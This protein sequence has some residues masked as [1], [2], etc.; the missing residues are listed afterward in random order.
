MSGA[1]IPGPQGPAGQQG[2]RGVQGGIGAQGPT[3]PCGPTGAR[4]AQGAQ[5]DIGGRGDTGL[6]GIRG[7]T[8]PIGATGGTGP[9]GPGGTGPTGERGITGAT[10]PTGPTGPSGTGPT[11]P[12]VTGPTGP[13]G[14]TGTTGNT[15]PTGPTGSVDTS[16]QNTFSA[17][18]IFSNMIRVGSSEIIFQDATPATRNNG[19]ALV[20]DDLWFETAT[21]LL[22]FWDG[23]RWLSNQLFSHEI[24]NPISAFGYY[25]F[26]FSPTT[27]DSTV[28]DIFVKDLQLCIKQTSFTP[29]ADYFT[30]KVRRYDASGNS[31]AV[32]SGLSN[33]IPS[34]ANNKR[35]VTSNVATMTTYVAH[36]LNVGQVVTIANCEDAT[37][38]GDYVITAIPSPTT[39]SFALTHANVGLT[40]DSSVTYSMGGYYTKMQIALD[41]FQSMTAIQGS[42]FDT[43]AVRVQALALRLEVNG[44]ANEWVGTIKVSY[45]LVHP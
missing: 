24:T 25:E 27:I 28:F 10:G 20:A 14:E 44:G 45:R 33:A 2:P 22:W 13:I 12:S 39:F 40:S 23:T 32:G 1:S 4:G 15:G 34:N 31:A 29:G 19:N 11:G 37:F 16:I 35:Q 42:I 30:A 17:T 5:G 21:N 8:G 9:T 18:Q 43:P 7:M 6:T 41:T 26:V 3:G 38:D 36:N